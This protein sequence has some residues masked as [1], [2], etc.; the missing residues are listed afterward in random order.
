MSK[1]LNQCNFIGRLGKDIE[2]KYTASG[3]AVGN[4]SIAFSDEYKAKAFKVLG[5]LTRNGEFTDQEVAAA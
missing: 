2:L 5:A 4:F 3:S 1:D